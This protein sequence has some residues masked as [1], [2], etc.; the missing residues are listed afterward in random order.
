MDDSPVRKLALRKGRK[1]KSTGVIRQWIMHR[2]EE[3]TAKRSA[4]FCKLNAFHGLSSFGWR[5]RWSAMATTR[6]WGATV[7]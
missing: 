7:I 6:E 3:E 1:I 5:S 2:P 4:I